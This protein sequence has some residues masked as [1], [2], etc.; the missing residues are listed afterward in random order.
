RQKGTSMTAIK[1]TLGLVVALA[2][3]PI[4]ASIAQSP[5]STDACVQVFDD[6]VD[7]FADKVELAYAQ[8]FSVSYYDNF[9]IVTVHEP[10]VGGV[11][12]TYVLV[13]CGTPAPELA[14][15]LAGATIIQTPVGSIFSASTTHNPMF[16]ALGAVGR[17]TGVSSLAYA[18]T[19]AILDA[20]AA[21][22]L[23]EFAATGALDI[24]IVIDAGPDMFM[25]GGSDNSLY[26]VLAAAGVPIVANAEWLE[27]TSLGRAEWIKFIA[28]FI[29]E[30]ALATAVFDEIESSYL[31][32]AAMVSAV[33]Q[34]ERPLVLAGSSFQGVF[35]ASGGRSYVAQTIEAAG[36]R[37]VFSNDTGTASIAFPDLEIVL[38]RAADAAIWIN[39]TIGYRTLADIVADEPRLA[40]LPSAQ[41]GQV[42]NYGRIAT[43][44]GG[45]AFFELGALRP[46]LVL[47]DLIEILHPGTLPGHEMTFY[48][49]ISLE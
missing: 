37:Y 9:K 41:S 46:D 7:Y 8:N 2:L 34:S 30:E 17:V 38:D 25:T 6:G 42:W 5:A 4:A 19:T 40:A 49:P 13:K 22:K 47:R 35:Y 14:G 15:E 18:T 3:A 1:S 48:Q 10:F 12:Q 21:G 45:V 39:S 16:D 29:D 26:D 11:S 27:P 31:G 28:L 33:E 43:P 32:A 36:G 24:E 23:I 44:A 20:G